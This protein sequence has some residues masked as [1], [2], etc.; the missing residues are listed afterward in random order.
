MRNTGIISSSSANRLIECDLKLSDYFQVTKL[1]EV[2]T[3][4]LAKVFSCLTRNDLSEASLVCKKW[5]NVIE[6]HRLYLA[7][8]RYNCIRFTFVD[9]WE[10]YIEYGF[11]A[12]QMT[13]KFKTEEK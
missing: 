10:L 2:P 8:H 13:N 4:I 9:N 6:K 11:L 5:N 7:L 3:E 1:S 12:L